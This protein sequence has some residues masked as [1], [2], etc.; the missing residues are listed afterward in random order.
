MTHSSLGKGN[1]CLSVGDPHQ[2]HGAEET[3]GSSSQDLANPA[4]G[5]PKGG[6]RDK[7]DGLEN[8]LTCN[9]GS[10]A[11]VALGKHLC[12]TDGAQAAHN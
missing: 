3:V 1:T 8:V 11:C 12:I 10:K 6:V 4:L 5:W 7:D 9:K 2:H